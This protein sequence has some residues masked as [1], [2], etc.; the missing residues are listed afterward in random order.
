MHNDGQSQAYASTIVRNILKKQG[1]AYQSP[2]EALMQLRAEG[3]ERIYMQSTTLMEGIEMK[4]I[5]DVAASMQP[6]FREIR[7][8]NPLLYSLEDCSPQVI[9][10]HHDTCQ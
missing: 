6:F 1:L 8:G 9:H 5:R 10:S 7:V 3:Y 4:S 2:L